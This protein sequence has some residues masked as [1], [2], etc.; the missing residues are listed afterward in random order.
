MAGGAADGAGKMVGIGVCKGVGEGGAEVQ[1]AV[2]TAGIAKA[3]ASIILH[4]LFNCSSP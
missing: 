3:V 2:T 1:P 4:V